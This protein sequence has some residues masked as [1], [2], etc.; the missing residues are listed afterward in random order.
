MMVSITQRVQQAM[1]R[2][3]R[4]RSAPEQQ[5]LQVV[6]NTIDELAARGALR[7]QEYTLP[8]TVETERQYHSACRRIA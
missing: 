1:E 2:A 3:A 4:T 7:R 8:S 5:Q 6:Q